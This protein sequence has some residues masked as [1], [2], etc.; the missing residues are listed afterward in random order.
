MKKIFI[1]VFSL[2]TLFTIKTQGTEI[3]PEYFLMERLIMLMEVSPTYISNDN[4]KELK[5][6]QIDDNVMTLIGN[7]ETPFYIY[8]S[9]GQK[10]LVRVGDYFYSPPTLSSIYA[11]DKKNFKANFKNKNLPQEKP[12]NTQDILQNNLNTPNMNENISN[13]LLDV[14]NLN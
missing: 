2:L 6:M 10:K 13:N 5:A 12:K 3:I 7:T 14:N 8:D 11:L 9:N 1:G 4:E